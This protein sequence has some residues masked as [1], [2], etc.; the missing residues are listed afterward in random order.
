[1]F[2]FQTIRVSALVFRVIQVRTLVL[3]ELVHIRFYPE[4]IGAVGF[5]MHIFSRHCFLRRPERTSVWYFL[6]INIKV[7]TEK[8]L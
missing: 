3:V 1:M 4:E 8:W 5:R 7:K 2:V 6:A